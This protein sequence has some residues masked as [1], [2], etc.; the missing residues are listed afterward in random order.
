MYN[1]EKIEELS[2]GDNDF[3]LSVVVLFIEEVPQDMGGIEKAIADKDF[4]KVYQ[5][6]HK[7]KPNVDLMGL[8]VA[9][10]KILEIEQSAKKELFDEVVEKYAVIKSEIDAAVIALKKDY[11]I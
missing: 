6:A 2:G 4:V 9:F 10:Q 3:I 11:N 8:D 5:H 1:L 7:I